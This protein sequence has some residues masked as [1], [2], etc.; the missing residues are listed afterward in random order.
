LQYVH[1]IAEKWLDWKVFQPRI[2]EWQSLIERDVTVDTRKIYSTDAFSA[3]VGDSSD[4][5][6][7]ENTLRG[8]IERRRAF[9]LRGKK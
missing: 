9:L 8:F 4:G 7:T 5:A 1:D 2:R 3:D 6:T